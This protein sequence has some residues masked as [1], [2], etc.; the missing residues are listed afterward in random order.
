MSFEHFVNHARRHPAM[1]SEDRRRQLAAGQKP[2]ALFIGC[3][4][5]RVIPSQITG[6]EPGKLFELRTAGNVV[7]QYVPDSASSEMATIEYAVLVLRVPDI[8]VCGHSHCGAVTA[9]TVAGRGLEQLPAMR[10]WL[11][12]DGVTDAPPEV[13]DPGVRSESKRHVQAQL[14]T[15]REYPFIADRLAAGDLRLHGWFYEI[16]TGL[17][18]TCPQQEEDADFL[19][20]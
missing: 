10:N 7:P 1:L 11:G 15:L 12:T 16:D 6:A 8:I 19:P 14:R 3:S 9:L 20:L 4:D 5:S 13:A 18:Y 17:V 2:T